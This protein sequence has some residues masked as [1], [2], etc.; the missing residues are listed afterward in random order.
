[1]TATV[2]RPTPR[3]STPDSR[4]TPRA[5]LPVWL[6]V[7]AP[8]DRRGASTAGATLLQGV[9][10]RHGG[11][12]AIVEIDRRRGRREARGLRLR[13]AATDVRA[14]REAIRVAS[15]RRAGAVA[16]PISTPPSSRRTWICSSCRSGADVSAA[17]ALAAPRRSRRADRASAGLSRRGRRGRGP[18]RDRQRA[19]D[20]RHR[21]RAARVAPS[22]RLAAALRAL[23][24]LAAL[25]ADDVSV[26]RSG[27]GEPVARRR[28]IATSPDAVRHRLLFDERTF[29]TYLVYWSEASTDPLQLSL[30]LPVEGAAGCAPADR[31][32]NAAGGRLHAASRRPA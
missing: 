27:R 26:A 12:I 3:R 19:R 16:W 30:T 20:A 29:A 2:S 17:E 8:S 1:M 11:A 24:P 13:L 18:A 15:W 4:S 23:A 9:L 31:R 14:E 7:A 28:A 25:M 5:R 10:S 21:R 22:E 6:A 32:R